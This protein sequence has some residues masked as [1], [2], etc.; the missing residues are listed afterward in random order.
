MSNRSFT[1][2]PLLIPLETRGKTNRR[3]AHRP[4]GEVVVV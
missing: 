1:K 2:P 3:A 4:K